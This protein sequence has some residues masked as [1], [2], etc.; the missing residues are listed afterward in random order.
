LTFQD[1]SLK[2][3]AYVRNEVRNG[4]LTERGFARRIGISQPHAHNV[5][6]GIRTFSPE[7]FDS[8]LKCL[9]L[10]LLDLAATEEIE[11]QLQLRRTQGQVAEV[12][13]LARPIGPGKL[14]P[15]VVNWRNSFPAPLPHGAVPSDLVMANLVND[16]EMIETLALFDIAL[17]DTSEPSRRIISPRGLYV[18]QRNGEAVLRYIRSGTHNYYLLTDADWGSPNDW[19]ALP[20]SAAQLGEAI[21]ARVLWLGRER[22]RETPPQRGRFLSDPISS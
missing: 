12:A 6:K 3:L 5:L 17:L 1:A 7:V 16:P 21:K 4:E 13:F 15:S 10:S 8:V 18:I 19:E 11:A 2:L 9:H 20:V 22:D 14:W